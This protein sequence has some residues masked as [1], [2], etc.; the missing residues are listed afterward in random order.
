MQLLPIDFSPYASALRIKRQDGQR[1]VF[2][3]IRRKYLVLTPEE[4]VRQL[5]LHHFIHDCQYN[6]NRISVERKL[7]VNGLERRYDVLVF[8]LQMAPFLLV[9][10][11]APEV[12]L[13]QSTCDQIAR[14]NMTLQVPYLMMT[15][16]RSNLCCQMDYKEK[17]YEYLNQLPAYPS[18]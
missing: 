8:D 15:N 7:L 16:G 18:H 6:P 4:F 1:W 9:E 17:Q 12:E 13:D 10:C 2:D 11:K 3:P 14:Y 5:L